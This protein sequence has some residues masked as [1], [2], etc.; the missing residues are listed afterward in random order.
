MATAKIKPLTIWKAHA[1]WYCKSY[2]LVAYDFTASGAMTMLRREYFKHE[3][4][5]RK[6]NMSLGLT[7]KQFVEEYGIAAQP[8]TVPSSSME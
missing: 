6:S 7:W 8:I 5:A 4:T 2:D 1:E 3:E